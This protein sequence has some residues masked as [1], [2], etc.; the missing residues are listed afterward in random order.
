MDGVLVDAREWHFDAL[1]EALIP[2]GY[3][4]TQSDHLNRFN[5]LST[6]AKL[7]ILSEEFDF[8]VSLHNI[9]EIVKQERTLRIAS[10]N[11]FPN[12]QH[13]ILLSRLA[14]KKIPR[15]VVTNSIE[16][17]AV[18]LLSYAKLLEFLDVLITNQD[19]VKQKPDPEGYLLA[20]KK[21]KVDPRETI[22]IEDGEYG[23]KAA[24]AAG[25]HV[26]K[27]DSPEDVSLELIWD[28]FPNLLRESS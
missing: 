14:Q 22:V 28:Y 8:P 27:V 3:A 16:N 20:C 2:F 19:V 15:G 21:L 9:V 4:I 25:C 12:V 11:C 23:I 1:N 6:R 7:R 18:S 26:I 24:S 10:Q 17:S 5:G 13:Q